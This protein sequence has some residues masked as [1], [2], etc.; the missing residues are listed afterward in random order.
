MYTH[1]KSVQMPAHAQTCTHLHRY[2][3]KYNFMYIYTHKNAHT[4]TKSIHAYI[5]LWV[6]TL[7]WIE[8]G[9]PSQNF[10]LSDEKEV[11]GL[12]MMCVKF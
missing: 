6:Y 5:Y 11:F 9:L 12:K 4:Y 7:G 8:N 1:T 10:V 2:I 3:D